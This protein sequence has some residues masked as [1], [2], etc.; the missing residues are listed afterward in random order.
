VR[1]R[2]FGSTGLIVSDIGVGC[3]RLGGVFSKDTS[4]RD[5][6]NLLRRAMDAGIN[7]FDTSDMYSHGQSEVVLGKAIKGRRRADVL[8]AT[9]GGYVWPAE[10]RLLGRVKPLVR[11]AVRTLRLRRPGG[12]PGPPPSVAQD[13]T[14]RYLATALEASLHRLGTDYVD[15]YQLHSPPRAVVDAGEY[16]EVLD[17][18]RAQGKVRFFGVAADEA[19]DIV[20]FDRQPSLSSLQMPFSVLDQRAAETVLPKAAALGIGV[21]S[22]SCFAAGLLVGDRSEAELRELTPD[23]PAIVAFRATAQALG[24]PRKELAL[25]FNLDTEPIAVT[26]VGM[27]SP[28]QLPEILRYS[29]APSLTPDELT[30][31]HAVTG[32]GSPHD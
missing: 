30:R 4:R 8:V 1:R 29:T 2:P 12:P 22:R 16:I 26:V 21:I 31:L 25:R 15:I 7:L 23:W 19:T 20:A 32:P 24:R 10:S 3:S 28:K 13:F 17:D 14:P 11:P 9:K 27:R 6:I 18:L 5:E